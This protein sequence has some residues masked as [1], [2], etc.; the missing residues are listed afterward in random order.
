ML[1]YYLFF[2]FQVAAMVMFSIL[3]SKMVEHWDCTELVVAMAMFS[4]LMSDS[5]FPSP[6][7]MM[8]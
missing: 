6:N 3:Y 8:V 7:P 2:L 5:L 1:L 4:A